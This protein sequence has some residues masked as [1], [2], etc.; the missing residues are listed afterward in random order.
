MKKI[1][2]LLCVLCAAALLSGCST[3]DSLQLDLSQGCGAQVKLLHLNARTE[4]KRQRIEEFASILENAQPLEKDLSLF[5]YCPDYLMEI[6]RDGQKTSAI[7]DLNGDFVDFR[8]P[9]DDTV[10]RSSMS[11]QEL[12]KLLHQH[13]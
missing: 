6:T 4:A 13:S 11:V 2:G 9:D 8:Y 10:Y 1:F 3:P 7:V 12:K 5:A